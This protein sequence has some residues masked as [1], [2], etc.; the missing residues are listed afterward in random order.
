MIF[1]I[2]SY[3]RNDCALPSVISKKKHLLVII[4]GFTKFV[5]L[6]PVNST[7]TREVNLCRPRRIVSARGTCFT[8]I[9]FAKFL[10]ENTIEHVRVAT[11]SPQANGQV[12]RVN[13]N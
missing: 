4:D 6:F 1:L 11:A 3:G 10:L 5:E 12:E 7:S 8:S 2:L 9:E 13:G